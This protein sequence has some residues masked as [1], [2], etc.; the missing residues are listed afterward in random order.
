MEILAAEL[1][2]LA[3]EFDRRSGRKDLERGEYP[4]PASCRRSVAC[5]AGA[6]GRSN[7]ETCG[8]IPSPNRV[9][10]PCVFA[11]PRPS[12]SLR[13]WAGGRVPMRLQDIDDLITPARVRNYS[14]M[15]AVGFGLGM[16]GWLLSMHADVDP[17][18][19]PFGYDFITFYAQSV[20][21]LQGKA[22][23]AYIPFEIL[24]VEQAVIPAHTP[25]YLWHYPPLFALVTLPL[26][27]VPYKLAYAG[28][29]GVPFALYLA[30]IRRISD[31]RWALL[32]PS[33]FP[34]VFL[35][36][37]HGQTGFLNTA[38]LG[39]G[40][41]LLERRSFLA[42]LVLGLLVYK[43]HFGVLLPFLF[44][45]TKNWRAF[46]G[47][48]LSASLFIASSFAVF[49]TAP[50]LMFLENLTLV[51]SLLES[52]YL[53]WPKIPSW[54]V[55]FRYL[56]VPQPTAYAL[57]AAIALSVCAAALR[58]WRRSAPAGLKLALPS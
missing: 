24:D 50:W 18:G 23:L 56:G 26:P 21:A 45:V 19:K 9:L 37:F 2:P 35:N 10:R 57:H 15:M 44:L 40:L 12:R 53:P 3:D 33:A 31:H 46:A 14:V 39:F 27:L 49:G 28:F 36:S 6:Q 4:S 51:R 16:I 41:L 52:G 54:F 30:L 29:V 20:M 55:T 25:V 32:L 1:V 38:V 8:G 17:Y 58:A 43:P 47:A 5:E 7:G 34:A 13:W 11:Q 22:A 42:G 48:A